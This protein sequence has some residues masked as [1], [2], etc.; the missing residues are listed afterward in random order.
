MNSKVFFVIMIALALVATG[1]RNQNKQNSQQAQTVAASVP[2]LPAD[3]PVGPTAQ[4]FS[5]MSTRCTGPL[6]YDTYVQDP[7]AATGLFR[8]KHDLFVNCRLPVAD[9]KAVAAILGNGWIL[10]ER[11]EPLTGGTRYVP[12]FD[13]CS[14]DPCKVL[15]VHTPVPPKPVALVPAAKPAM[16]FDP[17][18]VWDKSEVAQGPEKAWK[19]FTCADGSKWMHRFLPSSEGGKRVFACPGPADTLTG[20]VLNFERPQEVISYSAQ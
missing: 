12:V 15:D 8:I 5:F 6:G 19:P 2:A 1:C 7:S 20:G 18:W 16:Q 13:K 11:V 3:T 17:E 14:D 10:E 4:F 9:K